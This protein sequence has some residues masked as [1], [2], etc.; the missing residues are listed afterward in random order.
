MKKLSWEYLR[1]GL[2]LVAKAE[3][4]QLEVGELVDAA[5]RSSW[6]GRKGGVWRATLQVVRF[7]IS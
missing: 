5:T 7:E 3:V 4:R 2:G 6:L 1:G